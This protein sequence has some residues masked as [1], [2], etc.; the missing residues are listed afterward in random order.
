MMTDSSSQDSTVIQGN[1]FMETLPSARLDTL[2]VEMQSWVS[3]NQV[4]AQDESLPF[5]DLLLQIERQKTSYLELCQASGETLQ[6]RLS[7]QSPIA[8]IESI[9][10]LCTP[11]RA[12]L[13]ID[14]LS[15]GDDRPSKSTLTSWREVSESIVAPHSS[16]VME[17]PDGFTI[18][19]PKWSLSE[20]QKRLISLRESEDSEPKMR[21]VKPRKEPIFKSA[22]Q[23]LNELN[24]FLELELDSDPK[25]LKHRLLQI[26]NSR[27]INHE[28]DRLCEALV[29][30]E[31]PHGKRL[32][33]L[34]KSVRDYQIRLER[35][36]EEELVTE[37]RVW[38]L[39]HHFKHKTITLIGG[40]SKLSTLNRLREMIPQAEISWWETEAHTGERIMK[41]LE[42]RARS[43]STDVILLLTSFIGHRISKRFL[44][45]DQYPL[46]GGRALQV[47]L[48]DK[49]YGISKL[50]QKL[51]ECVLHFP[52]TQPTVTQ[53]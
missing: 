40:K 14:P 13:D 47:R 4:I 16:T 17:V 45:L 3:A 10:D 20:N 25:L 2:L 12:A 50:T 23:A 36:A 32:K 34:R 37:E 51:E 44:P 43:G 5:S 8:L 33:A 1:T 21:S 9:I 29:G 48:I 31:I 18:G 11:S 35:E 6:E 19:T 52:V 49:G 24:E 7:K 27:L 46:H 39:A 15:L 26:I 30:V 53:L 41:S 28:D 42:R 22:D 38:A